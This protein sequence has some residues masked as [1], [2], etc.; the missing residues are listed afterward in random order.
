M[1]L[2]ILAI[3]D[4]QPPRSY[5][6]QL[7]ADGLENTDHDIQSVIHDALEIA[8]GLSTKAKLEPE[9]KTS[10]ADPRF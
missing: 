9:N 1:R 5:N 2:T 10:K 3:A 6:F 8:S 4:S 7:R